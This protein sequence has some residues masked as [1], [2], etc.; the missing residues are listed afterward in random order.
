[1]LVNE[2]GQQGIGARPE[3]QHIV[4]MLAEIRCALGLECRKDIDQTDA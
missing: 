1:M 4:E 2:F 3:M